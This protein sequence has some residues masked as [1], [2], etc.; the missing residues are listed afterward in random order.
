[1]TSVSMSLVR[2]TQMFQSLRATWKTASRSGRFRRG[3]AANSARVEAAESSDSAPVKRIV[4]VSRPSQMRRAAV[5]TSA[6]STSF[7]RLRGVTTEGA[8]SSS[9][10]FPAAWLSSGAVGGGMLSA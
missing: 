10:L 2:P 8:V 4:F 9:R 5:T 6:T 1:M 7:A 3:D